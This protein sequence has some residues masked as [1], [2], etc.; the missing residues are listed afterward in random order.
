[1]VFHDEQGIDITFSLPVQIE[2]GAEECSHFDAKI[3]PYYA[4]QLPD[5][6]GIPIGW[7]VDRQHPTSLT[8]EEKNA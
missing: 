7:M 2:V 4:V 6:G 8:G 3:I 5:L 1:V